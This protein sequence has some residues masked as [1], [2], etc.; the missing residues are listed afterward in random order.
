MSTS[1]E[2]PT[3][4]DFKHAAGLELAIRELQALGYDSESSAQYRLSELLSEV[5]QAAASNTGAAEAAPETPAPMNLDQFIGQ[6]LAVREKVGGDICVAVTYAP[7][8]DGEQKAMT[9]ELIQVLPISC[10]SDYDIPAQQ[11]LAIGP[12]VDT[13]G[14]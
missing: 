13:R 8:G 2:Q 9:H 6:L 12:V 5:L 3:V 14:R 4:L 11:Y 10:Y 7:F 1:N